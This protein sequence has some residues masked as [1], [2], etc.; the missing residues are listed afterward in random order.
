VSLPKTPQESE[1]DKG[2]DI[3]ALNRASTRELEAGIGDGVIDY[4]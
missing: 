4:N 3:S 1:K 2:I